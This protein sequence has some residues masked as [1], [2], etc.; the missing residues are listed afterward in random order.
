VTLAYRL[1]SRRYQASSPEGS[2]I[3]GGRW[4]PPG[5]PVI[6]AASNPSLAALEVLTHYELLPDDFALTEI[7]IPGEIGIEIVEDKQLPADWENEAPI[8]GPASGC[9]RFGSRWVI[10]KRSTVLSVPSAVMGLECRTERNL[11]INPAAVDFQ[12]IRFSP[13]RP[14]RF[15][16]RL[17]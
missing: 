17:K 7:E 4:N 2:R 13:P 12:S 8:A 15:D 14:F 9:Q 11:V 6:Y 3:Y 16:S 1:C 5:V 10:E